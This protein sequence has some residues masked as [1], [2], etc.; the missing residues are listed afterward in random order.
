MIYI[1]YLTNKVVNPVEL[2]M[3]PVVVL[4]Q[5]VVPIVESVSVL[6]LAVVPAQD[7]ESETRTQGS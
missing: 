4:V 1:T 2:T 5:P 3:K 6:E 7:D